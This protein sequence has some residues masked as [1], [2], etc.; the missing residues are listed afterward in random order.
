V[1][2]RCFKVGLATFLLML[3]LGSCTGD[4]L[5]PATDP[6]A[7][8][9]AQRFAVIVN[10]NDWRGALGLLAPEAANPAQLEEA[11]TFMNERMFMLVE[12]AV[13]VSD[14]NLFGEAGFQIGFAGFDKPPSPSVESHEARWRFFVL[15][16]MS[17]NGWRVRGYGYQLVP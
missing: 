4:T 6:K 3:V 15:V 2:R 8:E 16:A 10:S 5:D 14:A 7:R 13:F 9:L 12:E 1:T 17:D 11:H